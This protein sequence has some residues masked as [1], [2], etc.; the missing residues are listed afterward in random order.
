M[1]H[2]EHVV[3]DITI[4]FEMQVVEINRA[5]SDK[6]PKRSIELISLDTKLNVESEALNLEIREIEHLNL[7]DLKSTSEVTLD[8]SILNLQDSAGFILAFDNLETSFLD[9]KRCQLNAIK[10]HIVHKATE[11]VQ[12]KDKVGF[13]Q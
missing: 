13:S 12:V 8:V 4:S 11:K 10:M 1:E 6:L 3:E 5:C 9:I 2:F 7:A